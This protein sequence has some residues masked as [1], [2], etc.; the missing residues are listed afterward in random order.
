MRHA[1]ALGQCLSVKDKIILADGRN[2]VKEVILPDLE[3]LQQA[4]P[5]DW[6]E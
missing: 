5:G 6:Q 4:C 3:S 1:N 2:T